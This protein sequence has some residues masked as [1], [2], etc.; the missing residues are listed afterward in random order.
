[1]ITKSTQR[2]VFFCDFVQQIKLSNNSNFKV[3]MSVVKHM[4]FDSSFVGK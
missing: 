1:M 4:K 2:S 3:V